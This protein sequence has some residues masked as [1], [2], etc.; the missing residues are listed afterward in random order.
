MRIKLLIIL[1]LVA[2][3]GYAQLTHVPGY[4]ERNTRDH[5][6]AIMP[7][8]AAHVPAFERPRLSA[9]AGVRAGNLMIDSVRRRM[10][11]S[12]G[13]GV[14]I[15]LKDTT[16]GGND[17]DLFG[18]YG[19]SNGQGWGSSTLSPA[20]IPGVAFQYYNNVLTATTGDPIGNANTG[21]AWPAFANT[22]YTLT[23]RKICFVPMGIPASTMNAT[24]DGGF[25]NWDST[26]TLLDTAIAR[27]NRAITALTVAGYT[28]FFRGVLT[29]I[30]GNDALKINDAT[31]NQAA[32]IT[33]FTKFRA[34]IRSAFGP[35]TPIYIHQLGKQVTGTDAGHALIR[36]AQVSATNADSLT[37]IVFWNAQYFITR[38]LQTD[39]YH[40][41]QSG[42]N[43]MGRIM[44]EQIANSGAN[45]FQEQGNNIWF[46]KGYVG[47]GATAGIP[48]Y[49]LYVPDSANIAGMFLSRRG[50]GLSS[51]ITST[52]YLTI[53]P[54][55]SLMIMQATSTA[56]VELR[57]AQ[58]DEGTSGVGATPFTGVIN[59]FNYGAGGV[60][61]NRRHLFV[62]TGG[63][64]NRA[65]NIILKPN[66]PYW[67]TRDTTQNGTDSVIV[68]LNTAGTFSVMGGKAYFDTDST[69][70]LNVPASSSSSDSV[71]VKTAL[72][73]VKKRAQSD[74]AGGGGSGT[75]NANA[76]SGFRWLKPT[77][78]EIKTVFGGYGII[79]D[80]TTNTDALTAKVD[81]AT[82]FPA[83]AARI[84][85]GIPDTRVI[86]SNAG[87]TGHSSQFTFTGQA[88][89]LASTNTTQS[90]TSS[91]LAQTYN[92]LTT[93]TG[94]YI[95]S[96][97]L[98][99]GNLL[100]LVSTSTAKTGANTLLNINSSGANGS[101]SIT[102][103]GATISV[104]NT[105]TT[106]E[107]RALELTASGATTNWAAYAT[108]GNFRTVGAA[109]FYALNS[110][111]TGGIS[112][113]YDNSTIGT[114]GTTG[115]IRLDL[116]AASSNI[117]ARRSFVVGVGI[118]FGNSVALDVYKSA[119]GTSNIQNWRS[120]GGTVLA[121]VDQ[122]GV[123]NLGLAGSAIGKYTQSGN[124]SGTIT[125]QPQA[126]AGTY[127]WNW[128][129]TAGSAGQAL[130]SG[131]GGS[132]AMTYLDLAGAGTNPTITGVANVASSSSP[133]MQYTRAGSRVSLSGYV[134]IT[135]TAGTTITTFRV[136]LPI[137]SNFIA[138]TEA[139][140]N[141]TATDGTT[142]APGNVTAD[143]TNDELKVTFVSLNT[144][145]H[146][147]TF[148]ATYVIQ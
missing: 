104:T 16:E 74:I 41:S 79:W 80:S 30:G 18:I 44:A 62:T 82:T 12:P 146:T 43:E 77:S 132:T 120:S 65:G 59:G 137:A 38:S 141:A 76:G 34:R 26:G 145:S 20:I 114:I 73:V 71:L 89:Q 119:S 48:A 122:S 147:V 57:M 101:S 27:T 91:A 46:S 32:Y 64:S 31:I 103:R 2:S 28:V 96:S 84:L 72:G 36:A 78:Q 116:D 118:D 63:T 111:G 87:A 92:S 39:Q 50:F 6:I 61:D 142:F 138:A 69:V 97:S 68:E 102:N 7:D 25:G 129:T 93:G 40:Y 24:A 99:S 117:L 83:M 17:V 29:G 86:Y 14:L 136:S 5:V 3:A 81:T 75:N 19:D 33:S 4:V 8:S 140:G 105:G 1:M 134:N 144:S 90:T 15:R 47:I 112:M 95:A 143:G 49:P 109:G 127:N 66:T 23:G 98:T 94:Q 139:P 55:S 56:P 60:A 45:K 126:A 124:T 106:S 148:S 113:A 88:L 13:S 108:A 54:G 58:T 51:S 22:W 133:V 121:N 10:Y 52:S 85:A 21:S 128:P 123:L 37:N 35:K 70:I 53:K 67:L 135:P 42:Y 9:L 131:G 107:N 130:M 115:G 100:S 110:A 11:F 125:F